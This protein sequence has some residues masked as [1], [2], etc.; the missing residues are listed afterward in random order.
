MRTIWGTAQHVE[1]IAEGILWVST[2]SHGGFKLNR[3]MNAQMPD[4]MRSKGGWY[5]EDECWALVAIVF[6]QFFKEEQKLAAHRIFINYFPKA[7]ERY[8]DCVILPGHSYEKD[9]LK[10]QE[11]TKN[12]WVVVSAFANKPGFVSTIARRGTEEKKFLVPKN[13]YVAGKFGFVIDTNRHMEV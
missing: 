8:Y 11:D 3:K 12:S 9:K 4:Y 13:E 1:T 6:P 2:A 10:F 7:F 5:E